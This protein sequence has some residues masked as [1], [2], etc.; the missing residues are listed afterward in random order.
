MIMIKGSIHQE[1]IS[2]NICICNKIVPKYVKQKLTKLKGEIGSSTIT[3]RDFNT[4]FYF[5]LLLTFY[6]LVFR[7]RRRERETSIG[8]LLHD[9]SQGPGPQPR[10]VP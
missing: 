1:N 4:P 2:I 9:P 5:T 8:C 3:T 6:L 7:E 10:H